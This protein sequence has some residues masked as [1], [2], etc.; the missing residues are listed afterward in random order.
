MNLPRSD[1]GREPG[2]IHGAK[3][4]NLAL[5]SALLGHPFRFTT[6]NGDA[7]CRVCRRLDSYDCAGEVN[8]LRRLKWSGPSESQFDSST[9]REVRMAVKKDAVIIQISGD[10]LHLVLTICFPLRYDWDTENMSALSP[11][12]RSGGFVARAGCGQFPPLLHTTRTLVFHALLL[13]RS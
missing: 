3:I 7:F 4:W 2:R 9:Q 10:A 12:V 5:A 11:F 1:I 13:I 8:S 6:L